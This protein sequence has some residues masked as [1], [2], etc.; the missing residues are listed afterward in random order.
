[1]VT[2]IQFVYGGK[3]IER[4]WPMELSQNQI[5]RRVNKLVADLT[6]NQTN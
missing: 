4:T 3:L 6:T 5:T 1:M 2:I